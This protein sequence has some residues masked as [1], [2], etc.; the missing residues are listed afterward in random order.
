M[1]RAAGYTTFLF[2]LPSFWESAGRI[3]DLAGVTN[4]LNLLGEATDPLALAAD[5]AALGE[6]FRNALGDALPGG[7]PGE[8]GAL[9]LIALALAARGPDG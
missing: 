1:T 5:W 9:L 3:L 8:V 2:A 7:T 4:G 6:D